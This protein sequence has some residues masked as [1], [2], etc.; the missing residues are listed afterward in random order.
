MRAS[1]LSSGDVDRITIEL[2][3][4][5]LRN[6]TGGT[7]AASPVATS[8]DMF[9]AKMSQDRKTAGHNK[10]VADLQ[11][12][13]ENQSQEMEILK[14]Q[15]SKLL[16]ICNTL[17]NQNRHFAKKLRK[18]KSAK[19]Q[20]KPSG[21]IL[22]GEEPEAEESLSS[23]SSTELIVGQIDLPGELAELQ[24][25]S[26]QVPDSNFLTDLSGHYKKSGS[27]KSKKQRNSKKISKS[28]TKRRSTKPK[29]V[30]QRK[31]SVKKLSKKYAKRVS[32]TKKRVTF[33]QKKRQSKG[34]RNTMPKLK[35]HVR[36]SV[37][38]E[39]LRHLERKSI[40]DRIQDMKRISPNFK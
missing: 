29:K 30:P 27:W 23:W 19:K 15:M 13:Y 39:V 14:Q 33:E 6:G 24:G 25:L 26:G 31:G 21:E 37:G 12:K 11:K 4:M 28:K 34:K 8:A 10:D 17:Q 22:I 2:S 16:D 36:K 3:G 35:S 40:Q 38:A 7:P 5:E 1:G 20:R 32:D 18:S 9:A